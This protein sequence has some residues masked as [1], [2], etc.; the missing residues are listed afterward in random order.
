MTVRPVNDAPTRL[1]ASVPLAA[2]PEDAASPSQATVAS[3]FNG[4]GANAAFSDATDQ[5]L[6][7][8]SLANQLA[9][10]VI[11]GNSADAATEGVWQYSADGAA[12]TTVTNSVTPGA[13][14]FITPNYQLRFVPVTDYNGTP[15]GLTVRL[16]DDAAVTP[17]LPAPGAT[18]VDVT[19]SGG[20]TRYS[21]SANAV[22]LTTR[23][24]AVNDAPVALADTGATAENTP[25]VVP[26]AT[27]ILSNDTD[28]DSS[29]THSVSAVNGLT[30]NVGAAVTGSNGG[31]FTIAADGSYSFNPGTAFDNLAA[32]A[33]R[34]TSVTY[35]NLDSNGGSA[36]STLT[37]TVTGANDAPVL[38][39]IRSAASKPKMPAPPAAPWAPWYPRWPG[40]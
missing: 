18:N 7:G 14:V 24:T 5:V 25:L 11:V 19:S 20:T 22:T 6:P 29:D 27:G 1:L 38:G 26:A 13:G 28:V 21:N 30:G 2:T 8:G 40:A 39:H 37:I 32:G 23:I 3:L 12:W 34:T 15:P 35:T 36:G 17:A 31:S 10:V 16:V 9:G 33:T 4:A